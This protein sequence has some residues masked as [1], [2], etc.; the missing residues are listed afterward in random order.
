MSF[1]S[2]ILRILLGLAMLL[3]LS[4]GSVQA[5]DGPNRRQAPEPSPTNL[6]IKSLPLDSGL[7]YAVRIYQ[8]KSLAQTLTP[9][10]LPAYFS[11]YGLIVDEQALILV[12]ISGPSGGPPVEVELVER[13]GGKV[14][15]S[16]RH[17]TEA[18]L[19]LNTLLE[20]AGSLPPGYFIKSVG[21]A[22]TNDVDGEGPAATGSNTYRNN[23]ADCSGMV[24]GVIDF[25]YDRLTETIANGD[26]PSGGRIVQVN[27]TSSM[28]EAGSEHGT[29]VAETVYDHCPG[30]NFRLYRVDNDHTDF[31]TA[32][33]NA[34]D[35][36]VDVI[37][38]S[39]SWYN[40]G[41]EDN[42]GDICDAVSNLDETIFFNSAGNRAE[43][44][45]QGMYND[46]DSDGW[47]NWPNGSELLEMTIRSSVGDGFVNAYLS[48]DLAGGNA[49]YDLYLYDSS[50]TELQKSN[51]G[52]NN[53]ESLYR[54]N[55][56]ASTTWY[57]AIRRVSGATAE[58]ELFDHN[59]GAWATAYQTAANSTDSPSNC[60]WSHNVVV[61]G[62]VDWG[63][64]GGAGPSIQSYSSR[65][66][67]NDGADN[68]NLVAPT[69][70]TTF[71]YSG[72]FGGTSAAAPNAAGT[73]AAFWSDQDQLSS[74]SIRWLL[75]RMAF[76]IKD[77]GADGYDHTFGYGGIVLHPWA[78]GT[79]F[80]DRN[81]NNWDGDIDKPFYYVSDAV[82][83]APAGGRLVFIAGDYTENITID[84]VLIFEAL[85][86]VDWDSTLGSP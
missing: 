22:N 16:W 31:A 45:W 68:L 9:Q 50:V 58:L 24:I 85:D 34:I 43:S 57:F 8:E 70:T 79:V 48:W 84:K 55:T 47:H 12:E 72:S 2:H 86:A 17:L 38:H 56:G 53:Y 62:A 19:P 41:W 10:D 15:G 80:L 76:A 33:Q 7:Y 20:L 3:A 40:T 78:T 32:I 35:N 28:F 65:G 36:N 1:S 54:A 39:A 21:P 44:H 83:A 77:W 14:S 18:L 11:A 27:Y 69:N 6:E 74:W 30:A 25:S 26:L 71:A 51:N 64:Y 73:A 4:S 23:G 13:F 61:I 66:P 5:Q 42:T 82:A 52:G 75:E 29:A 37:A 60:T 63:V 81:V 67:T 46:P 59:G 49:D